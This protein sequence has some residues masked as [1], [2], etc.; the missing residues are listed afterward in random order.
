MSQRDNRIY[1]T[2]KIGPSFPESIK[3]PIPR[4]TL[5]KEVEKLITPVEDPQGYSLIVGEHGSGKTSVIRF[6]ISRMKM[7]KG[8]VYL[9]IPN[10]DSVK[11]YPAMVT[12]T[13]RK[14]LGWTRDATI[15]PEHGK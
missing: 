2:L 13:I 9:S 8:L 10:T 15:D 1:E 14:A 5:V 4:D 6:A 11:S 12:A 3:N 7:P